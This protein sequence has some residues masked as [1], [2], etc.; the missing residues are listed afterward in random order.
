MEILAWLLGF[1]KPPERVFIV[2]GD[3]DASESM[4]EKIREKFGWDVV[5]P[6]LFDSVELIAH[7]WFF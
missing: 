1:N 5:V 7:A 4:A 3:D 6:K 2:H